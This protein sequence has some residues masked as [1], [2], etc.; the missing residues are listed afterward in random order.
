MKQQGKLQNSSRLNG[1]EGK[2]KK[3]KKKKKK[4][5]KK[6]PKRKKKIKIIERPNTQKRKMR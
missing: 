5:P 3:K 2:G 4:K 6:K 1:K